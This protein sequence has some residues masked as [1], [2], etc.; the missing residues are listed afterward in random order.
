MAAHDVVPLA[1]FI[2][3]DSMLSSFIRGRPSSPELRPERLAQEVKSTLALRERF[4]AERSK[5]Y[6]FD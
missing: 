5:Q 2:P 3:S 1:E 4:E 6:N